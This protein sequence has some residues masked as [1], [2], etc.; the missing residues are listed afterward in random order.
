MARLN[1]RRSFRGLGLLCIAVAL[2]AAFPSH[3]SGAQSQSEIQTLDDTQIQFARGVYQR[4][5]LSPALNTVSS[6]PAD[7]RG[8]VQLSPIG[9]LRPWNRL[10]LTLP[11]PIADAGV[12]A[13][14]KRLYVVAGTD[15]GG[16]A[17]SVYWAN[18]NQVLGTLDPHGVAAADPRYV[19]NEWL[20]DPLPAAPLVP[21]CG[22]PIAERTRAAVAAITTGTNSGFIYVVGGSSPDSANCGVGV[23]ITLNGVQIGQVLA[24]GDI[25]WTSG[26]QLPSDTVPAVGA[27]PRGVEQASAT[28]VRT[29]S[30]KA[31]LYVIGGLSTYTNLLGE[32]FSSAEKSVYRAEINTATG[33]LGAWQRDVVAGTTTPE[34]V[35]LAGGAEGIYDHAA[36]H[37]TS[38]QVTDAG[39]TVTDGIVIAGGFNV[40]GDTSRN[41][42]VYRATINPADGDL[43][44]DAKPSTD[45]NDVSLGAGGQTGMA[46]LSYN[47]KLYMIAG[48]DSPTTTVNWVLTT[49]Y[50]DSLNIKPVPGGPGYFIGNGTPVLSPEGERS[51]AGAVIVDALPPADNPTGDLGTAWA[52]VVGGNSAA[53]SPTNTIFVGRIG[54]DESLDNSER[55]SDGWFYSSTFDVTFAQQ[56][57]VAKNARVLSIRWAA[58]INRGA[59]GNPNGDIIVQFRKTLRAD[60]NCPNDS[61]FG[62]GD[63]WFT[64][65]ADTGSGYFS[66]TSTAAAPFNT[67][68]LKDA[69]G[70][71]DFVATCFQYRARFL[72]NG[73]DGNQL[74]AA[75]AND[76][77]SPKLFSMNIE[78]VVAGNADIRVAQFGSSAPGG[79]L[80]SLDMSIQNLSLEGRDNTQNAGLE[81][82]DGSF[83]V[84]LC[85]AYAAP[86]Q[87]APTL[88]LPAMPVP[89]TNPRPACFKAYYPV[90]KWQMTAGAQL[91]LINSGQQTWMRQT[92]P[93][94]EEAIA[95]IRSLFSEPGTYKVAMVID[96]FNYVNEGTAGELNNRGEEASTGNQP[97]ILTLEITG[98]PVNIVGL[99]LLRR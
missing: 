69:F 68:T 56:G 22:V 34:N 3:R 92:G 19:N 94:T 90:Y 75:P 55:A 13:L 30:G 62:P 4:T 24:D 88:T 83:F 43:V 82:D 40:A 41:P 23:E 71:A 21:G 33:A 47:N 80:A 15:A 79:R 5:A 14:G 46:A 29:S 2:I 25:Q 98:P 84:H 6:I 38:T 32:D 42:F 66:K 58:E 60:P 7:Q 50:D 8:A 70:T 10:A 99:P 81:G 77:V 76:T 87:P 11:G 31:F 63:S 28:V 51:D 1:A 39:G 44:W 57:G 85:V 64:L 59:G 93:A 45:N 73:L 96:A 16:A 18:V 36:T 54:G 67:V 48:Q 35:P 91:A 26:P 12:V 37:V 86:G 61:V 74:P 53:G 97:Q 27:A 72:Q 49:T 95:D 52:F 65:D 89:D 78:K 9:A 20:N 17:D